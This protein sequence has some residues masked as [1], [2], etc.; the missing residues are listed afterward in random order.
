[1]QGFVELANGEVHGF[2]HFVADVPRVLTRSPLMI[3]ICEMLAKR[4]QLE[5]SEHKVYVNL[6]A[7]HSEVVTKLSAVLSLAMAG[8]IDIRKFVG[9][10]D[11]EDLGPLI[12]NK[13]EIE[14]LSGST[15]PLIDKFQL[16]RFLVKLGLHKLYRLWPRGK[17]STDM[18]VRTWIETSETMFPEV[19]AKGTVLIYPFYSNLR[20]H[21]TYF[22]RCLRN[23]DHVQP[24]GLPYQIFRFLGDWIRTGDRDLAIVRAETRAYQKHADEIAR[25]ATR[26]LFSGDEFESGT[27]GLAEALRSKGIRVRNLAHGLS[28]GAPYGGYSEFE[29]FNTAQQMYYG[30][31]SPNTEFTV[32]SRRTAPAEDNLEKGDLFRPVLVFLHS[33]YH[34]DGLRA[35]HR[36][37]KNLA[38][39][40]K[41][42][43]RE[44]GIDYFMKAHP[45]TDSKG[46][47]FFEKELKIPVVWSLADM[48]PGH[49]IF[50]TVVTTAF[51]DFCSQ[52]PFIFVNESCLPLDTV[53]G[54][55]P[56]ACTIAELKSRVNM[57]C[58]EET[59]VQVKQEQGKQVEEN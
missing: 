12:E 24:I 2:D 35:E 45:N 19:F 33:T 10:L 46:L 38:I 1:M 47:F 48:P 42:V 37:Q 51:Y 3:E 25:Y 53:Y 15:P 5:E 29:V 7:T 26:S 50:L 18:A 22:R 56:G 16:F 55:D 52:G 8:Q 43:S 20:R 23:L 59:W 57:L 58:H 44:L 34:K 9:P 27:V 41:D 14:R 30:L 28:F 11:P 54:F 32:R 36:Q 21:L 6:L 17:Q 4:L 13:F 39:A 40:A 49:P 31:K